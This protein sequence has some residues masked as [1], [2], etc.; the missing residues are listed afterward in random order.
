MEATHQD[1]AVL[2]ITPDQLDLLGIV[3]DKEADDVARYLPDILKNI[4]RAENEWD[5]EEIACDIRYVARVGRLQ[6]LVLEAAN[7]MMGRREV[8]MREPND[9]RYH[10]G[11]RVVCQEEGCRLSSERSPK[12]F[13]GTGEEYEMAVMYADDHEENSGHRANVFAMESSKP[14]KG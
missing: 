4:E 2:W 6:L 12:V 3:L 10:V 5:E 13:Q 1:T 14:L 9:Y 8:V 7:E 11:S